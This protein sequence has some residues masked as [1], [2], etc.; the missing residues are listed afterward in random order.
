ME[1]DWHDV[2]AQTE[3]ARKNPDPTILFAGKSGDFQ[4]RISG[5]TNPHV[6]VI[7]LS[8]NNPVTDSN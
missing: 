3:K 6:P 7:K 1:G 8:F 4:K 2:S 5:K